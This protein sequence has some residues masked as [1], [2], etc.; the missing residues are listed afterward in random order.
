MAIPFIVMLRESAGL[1]MCTYINIYIN[2]LCT[3]IFKYTEL[4]P[5]FIWN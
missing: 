3:E 1:D 2:I 5:I 4:A